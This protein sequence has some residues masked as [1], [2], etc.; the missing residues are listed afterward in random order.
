MHW[1]PYALLYEKLP[2]DYQ[3]GIFVL[4]IVL[5]RRQLRSAT[6]GFTQ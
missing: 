3:G 2:L 6:F 4:V 5:V 1:L